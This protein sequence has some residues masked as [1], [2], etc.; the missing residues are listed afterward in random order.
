[1]PAVVKVRSHGGPATPTSEAW[2][3]LSA[4]CNREYNPGGGRLLRCCWYLVSLICFE[5]G[6]VPSSR[7]KAWILRRF[8]ARIGRGLVV[9]PHVRVKY[10]WRLEVGDHCWIGQG[11]W[12]DNLEDVALGSHVCVSQLAYLCTGSHDYLSPGFDLIVKPIT[13]GDGAW[14]AARCVVCPGVSIGPN[15]VVAAGSVVT[16]D[17]PAAAVVAGNPA[18][19]TARVR[20]PRSR[21]A[22]REAG[23][24]LAAA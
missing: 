20:S 10:P 24:R 12:I 21:T 15:A 4:Y 16:R 8:G 9:K 2:V 1:M 3:D 22:A 19:P 14:L 17:V 23:P 7:L 18:R 5:S 6:L 11:A 13:V